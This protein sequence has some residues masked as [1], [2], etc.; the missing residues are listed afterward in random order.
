[1]MYSGDKPDVV[2]EHARRDEVAVD[3]LD[4]GEQPRDDERVGRTVDEQ[5]E[6]HRRNEADHRARIRDE[7]ENAG[8]HADEQRVRHVH[9]R[10]HDADHRADDRAVDE[11]AADEAAD[12]LVEIVDDRLGLGAAFGRKQT[13]RIA[14]HVAGIDEHVGG[15]TGTMIERR[16][17][18]NRR[19]HDGER[20]LRGVDAVRLHERSRA[21]RAGSRDNRATPTGMRRQQ[22]IGR[23]C[24]LVLRLGDEAGELLHQL[25]RLIDQRRHESQNRDDQAAARSS[26]TRWRSTSPP[27]RAR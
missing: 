18:R 12:D 11:L 25:L 24:Q 5:R 8:R 15:R 1:M 7:V 19:Q 26:R 2:L 20:F 14:L 10:Q 21:G 6:D 22:R 4:D 9:E 16:D 3:L 17:H 27:R 23:V 13:Q